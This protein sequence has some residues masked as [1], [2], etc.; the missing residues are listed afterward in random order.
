MLTV[1]DELGVGTHSAIR[2]VISVSGVYDLHAPME[3]ALKNKIFKSMYINATFGGGGEAAAV[4]LLANSPAAILRARLGDQP[5][6]RMF[7]KRRKDKVD[8]EMETSRLRTAG[9]I[10]WTLPPFFVLSASY[11]MGL[12]LD[13]VRFAVLLHRAGVDVQYETVPATTHLDICWNEVYPL[14]P[15]LSLTA[16][17]LC[18][19]DP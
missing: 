10:D 17:A 3:T 6:P 2:G 16:S 11:D 1:C 14:A 13:A 8:F 15:C 9:I 18:L 7:C 4:A 19:S 5:F 12:E